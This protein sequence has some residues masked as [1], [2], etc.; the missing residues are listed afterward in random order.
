M[1]L[2]PQCHD[3]TTAICISIAAGAK[4]VED[5][6]AA[7]SEAAL[8]SLLTSRCSVLAHPILLLSAFVPFNSFQLL[9]QQLVAC[10]ERVMNTLPTVLTPAAALQVE[11]LEIFRDS[12]VAGGKAFDLP[13]KETTLQSTYV[14]E[15]LAESRN[16]VSDLFR[17]VRQ[18]QKTEKA[19][20]ERQQA[21]LKREEEQKKR[22]MTSGDGGGSESNSIVTRLEANFG[23]FQVKSRWK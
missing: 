11:S 2:C 14:D 16:H 12:C 5:R 7:Q 9:N 19:K 8:K 20:Q 3:R 21:F 18:K 1:N 22:M 15:L 23:N 6:K 10:P 13:N 4:T 17:K